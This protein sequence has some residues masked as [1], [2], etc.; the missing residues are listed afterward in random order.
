MVESMTFERCCGI[1]FRQ[2]KKDEAV[3]IFNFVET[4]LYSEPISLFSLF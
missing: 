2:D 1:L 3:L 4:Y